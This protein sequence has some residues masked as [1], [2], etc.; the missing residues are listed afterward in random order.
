[1]TKSNWFQLL[2]L[3]VVQI[4]ISPQLPVSVLFPWQPHQMNLRGQLL[5]SRDLIRSQSLSRFRSCGTTPVTMTTRLDGGVESLWSRENTIMHLE[6]RKDADSFDLHRDSLIFV[7]L[8]KEECTVNTVLKVW[9]KQN[10]TQNSPSSCRLWQHDGL[11]HTRRRQRC[12]WNRCYSTWSFA[13]SAALLW[14]KQGES[15][16]SSWDTDEYS[17]ESYSENTLV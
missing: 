6:I 13:A 8:I 5:P 15:C 11:W 10:K 14:N 4:N 3:P 7:R 2:F 1:M 16:F 9:K 17:W 12:L